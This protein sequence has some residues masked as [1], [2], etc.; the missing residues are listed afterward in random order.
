MKVIIGDAVEL[1][2]NNGGVLVHQV[3]C[4]RTANS[5]I[6]KQIRNRFPKWYDHYVKQDPYLGKV[7]IFRD[8]DTLIVSFYAQDKYGGPRRQTDYDAF[9]K[10]LQNFNQIDGKGIYI[11]YMIGC[12][13]GRG[14]WQV[15]SALLESYLPAATIVKL[16]LYE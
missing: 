2:A 16:K 11:P 9:E 10:C 3:N 5:G 12:G 1:A 8:N 7:D 15:I 6:A 13:L 4:Q 14:D